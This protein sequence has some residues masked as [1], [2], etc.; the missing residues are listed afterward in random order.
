M[1]LAIDTATKLHEE[2]IK[3]VTRSQDLVVSAVEKVATAVQGLRAKSPI[4]PGVVAG[5]LQTAAGPV[6]KLVGTQSEVTSYLA[7]SV[8]DWAEVQHKFRAS[9]LEAWISDDRA[10]PAADGN[11]KA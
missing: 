11:A 4:V 3:A 10:A 8:R 1:S 5:P 6:T 2:Q 7:S 9:V